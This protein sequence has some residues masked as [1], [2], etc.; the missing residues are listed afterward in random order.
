[1]T[2]RGRV[3]RVPGRRFCAG[4]SGYT[5]VGRGP[6]DAPSVIKVA[7]TD[8]AVTLRMGERV[9]ATQN[10]DREWYVRTLEAS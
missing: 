10:Y 7:R 8:V 2:V 4:A 1:M 9:I 3:V 6:Y 5:L